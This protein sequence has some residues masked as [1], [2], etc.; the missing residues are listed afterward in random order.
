[1]KE[2]V[3]IVATLCKYKEFN[4]KMIDVINFY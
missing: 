2:P 3:Q 4:P 1:M